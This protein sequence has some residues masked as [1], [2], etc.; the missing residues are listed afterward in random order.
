MDPNHPQWDA[1]EAKFM[2]LAD[3]AD[4]LEKPEKALDQCR[5]YLCLNGENGLSPDDEM[6]FLDQ[7]ETHIQELKSVTIK[8][9]FWEDIVLYV[10]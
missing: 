10:P 8:T 1:Y 2:E 6:D 4:A 5:Y 7:M 3:L 9:G